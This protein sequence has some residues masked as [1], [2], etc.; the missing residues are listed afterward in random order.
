MPEDPRRSRPKI[1]ALS[2]ENPEW[3]PFDKQWADDMLRM[4]TDGLREE[5]YVVESFKFFE[6]L[7]VLDRF[8][9]REWLVWNWG[10]ELAGRPWTEAEVA[11]ELER[12][13][14]VYTGSPPEV[15]AF[16][17]NRMRAKERL[18]AAG[19]PT[20]PA[21]VFTDLSGVEAWMR[22]PAI[23]KGA[24]Q[25][26]SHGITS[27][28]IVHNAAELAARITYLRDNFQDDALVEPFLD[29]REFQVAVWGNG[30]PE[31]LPP[32]EFDYSM[33]GDVRDR[34]YTYDWKF[35]H[36]SRGYKEIKM[37][38]PAPADKPEWRARL[39]AAAL[40]A[41]RV[42][43]LRDYG[44]FD[45]RMLG[46]EPQILDVNP[47]PDLDPVSVIPISTRALGMTYGQMAD[48]IAR[49]AS[50]RMPH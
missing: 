1:V 4:L 32:V 30:N 16:A 7:S 42:M 10:E 14:F 48:R 46:D 8:D 39:E 43:G 5:G 45:M 22:Y 31:A 34:L 26:A 11:A 28:S 15:L 12:R 38:C 24:N 27:D 2:N 35:D 3:T 44:R 18:R 13:G 47:N 41:Y 49:F 23:V 36:D 50:A 20:L 25:H 40:A 9:P 21:R 37:P 19:L 17:Q 6:D 29:T 33:F